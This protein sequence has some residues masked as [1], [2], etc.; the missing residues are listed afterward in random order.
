MGP[1]T[2]WCVAR[3]ATLSAKS[4]ER[5]PRALVGEVDRERHRHA[6]RDA[7][8][9]EPDL[10]RVPRE[11]SGAGAPEHPAHATHTPIPQGQHAVGDPRDLGAVRD[12]DDG[13]A[14]LPRLRRAS[15]PR[16]CSADSVSRLP[17]GS[18]ARI[19]RGS[20]ARARAT[21]TRCCSPPDSRSG[22]A[23][24]RSA[25]PTSPQQIARPGRARRSSRA[26]DQLERQA[27]VLLDGQGRHE[28]EELEDEADV[29]APEQ[30]A[31]ALAERGD[32]RAAD[33]S[34]R[35]RWA[36]RSR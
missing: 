36:H 24:A 25:R 10:P 14:L 35:P 27:Q 18:S 22:K 28:V 32:D 4:G 16:T 6:E 19:S 20:W 31:L 12:R 30:G 2:T 13:L 15:S 17:V 21:A 11:V 7:E 8:D 5:A 26:A 23:P 1:P 33:G 34:P 9:G 3:P 29:A